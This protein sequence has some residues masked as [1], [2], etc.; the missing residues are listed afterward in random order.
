MKVLVYFILVCSINDGYDTYFVRIIFFLSN[1]IKF[2][3]FIL[4]QFDFK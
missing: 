1:T 2:T 3:I 4:E